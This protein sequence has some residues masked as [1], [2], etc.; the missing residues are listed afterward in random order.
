VFTAVV[1]HRVVADGPVLND[2]ILVSPDRAEGDRV[3]SYVVLKTSSATTGA[4]MI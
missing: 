1:P 4:P 2:P 3:V